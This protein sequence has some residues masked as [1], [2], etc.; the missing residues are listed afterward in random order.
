MVVTIDAIVD[1]DMKFVNRVDERLNCP[2]CKKVFDEPWQTSCGHRFCR[3]CLERLLGQE[4]PRCPKDGESI[5]RQQSFRDKCCEREV[6]N[7]QCFCRLNKKGCDWKGELRHLKTHEDSCQYGNVKCQACSETVERRQLAAHREQDCINRA[8]ACTYCG[9]EVWHSNMKDHLDVCPKFP[10]HCFLN[11]GEKG[12]PR[13]MMEEHM[14]KRCLKAEHLCPF[15]VHGCEFKGTKQ[16]IDPHV[17]ENIESHLEMMSYSSHEC[18]EKSKQMEEKIYRLEQEK[19]ALEHQLQNQAEVLAAARQ[20]IQTQQTKLS[21]VENSIIEQKRTTEKLLADL[22]AFEA[23]RTN[24][25]IVSSQMEEIMNTLRE[26]EKEVSSLQGEVARL[27]LSPATP[28]G[29]SNYRPKSDVSV[30]RES[31]RRLDRNEHQLALH[32]IQ[33]SD[34]DMQIQMLEATSYNGT[35]FWKIDRYS[36]RFQEAVSGK[37]L[38]I[39]SPPFY[40]GRF[41]YKV[42]ARLYPNG[43]GIGKGTHLSMFFVVMRGE[44]DALLPWPFLQKVHFRLIDQDRI[45]DAYDAF[46]PEPNSSSFKRPTSD[47]NIASGCPTFISHIE[48]RQGGYIRNDTMFIK[49]TVD[50]TGL[51]GDMW[52]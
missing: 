22:K 10:I 9:G 30:T 41:G 51:Q 13:D 15:S 16:T 31:E 32:D 49:I 24:G 39:Y 23:F 38:S 29:E 19:S 25:D 27:K 36:Q 20:N 44:Y 35:Y 2:I 6:L 1:T 42:C 26:H 46:R 50:T 45:R 28:K 7:L 33:L 37:T 48:L 40:V 21:H 11:C 43:D 4:D 5:S 17:V 34:H 18:N 8:V 14:T 12:I 52:Q 47:M 3:H